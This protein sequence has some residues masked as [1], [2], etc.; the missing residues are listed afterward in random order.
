MKYYPIEIT[1]P[2]DTDIPEDKIKKGD[3]GIYAKKIRE[4]IKENAILEIKTPA[5]IT[6]ANPRRIKKEKRIIYR[7]FL[8]PEP[9]M[10]YVWTPNYQI[11]K[12]YFEPKEPPS[13][14]QKGAKTMFSAYQDMLKAKGIKYS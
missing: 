9:M 6:Y 1:K 14:T 10:L 5:G 13:I 3:I 11:T 8:K 2:F 7:N 4:A 12:D